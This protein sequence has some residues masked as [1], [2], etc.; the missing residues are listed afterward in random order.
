MGLYL[1][2]VV[3][4]PKL[5]GYYSRESSQ[6]TN[7][8]LQKLSVL[9]EIHIDVLAEQFK[10]FFFSDSDYVANVRK[11][12]W[13]RERERERERESEWARE[14]EREWYGESTIGRERLYGREIDR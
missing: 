3:I 13:E 8:W 7:Y 2:A 6:T 1:D 10:C 11:I 4:I 5:L 9:S 14:S 12:Y